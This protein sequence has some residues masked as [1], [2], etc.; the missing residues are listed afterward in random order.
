VKDSRHD[1]G[2]AA[3][4]SLVRPVIDHAAQRHPSVRTEIRIVLSAMTNILEPLG[5]GAFPGFIFIATLRGFVFSSTPLLTAAVLATTSPYRLC[6][7][8]IAPCL[9]RW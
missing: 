5:G 3:Y 2:T 1:V 4:R 6:I 9:A 8:I 7:W